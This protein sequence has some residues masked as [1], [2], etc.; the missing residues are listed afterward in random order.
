MTPRTRLRG[1][2]RRVAPARSCR[3]KPD[4]FPYIR[5][6]V[7]IVCGLALLLMQPASFGQSPGAPA[8]YPT[9]AIRMT[10]TCDP[11]GPPP[12]FGCQWSTDVCDWICAVCDPFG[13]PPRLSCHWDGNL[14]NWLC[15]GYTGL[16]AT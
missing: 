12:R 11:P 2:H 6:C 1:M 3:R 5:R 4:L 9:R 8:V 10:A 13:A 7:A 15:P 16:E 14:C